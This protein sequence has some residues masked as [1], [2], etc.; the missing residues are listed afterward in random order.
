MSGPLSPVRQNHQDSW[1][2]WSFPTQDR[3]KA[4]AVNRKLRKQLAEFRSPQVMVYV[5]EKILNADLEKT[6][7]MWERKVEIAEVSLREPQHRQSFMSFTFL[8]RVLLFKPSIPIFRHVIAVRNL[9][10]PFKSYRKMKSS[11]F[12]V[13]YRI[14]AGDQEETR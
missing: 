8:S 9:S 3:A 4:E 13:R 5:R 1:F 2:N 10:S 12:S 14:F 7:K 6:I 11:L